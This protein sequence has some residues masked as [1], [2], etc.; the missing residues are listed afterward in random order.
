MRKIMVQIA[1]A[2]IVVALAVLPAQAGG[3]QHRCLADSISISELVAADT[4]ITIVNWRASQGGQI[5]ICL[6]EEGITTSATAP[7]YDFRANLRDNAGSASAVRPYFYEN[8]TAK[9]AAVNLSGSDTVW[10]AFYPPVGLVAAYNPGPIIGDNLR[11]VITKNNC[12]AGTVSAWVW[13]KQD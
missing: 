4:T 8:G 2:L 10:L 1:L 7:T 5:L 9:T 11:L 6:R 12:N 13:W 3:W